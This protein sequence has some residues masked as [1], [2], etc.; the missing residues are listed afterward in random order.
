MIQVTHELQLSFASLEQVACKLQNGYDMVQGELEATAQEA[1][2][3]PELE[4]Q[5]ESSELY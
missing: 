1:E 5:V 2:R 4:A 3:V